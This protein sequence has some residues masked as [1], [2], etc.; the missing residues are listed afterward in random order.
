M[1]A[2]TILALVMAAAWACE[3]Q[4]NVYSFGIYSCGRSYEKQWIVGRGMTCFGYEQYEQFLDDRG[5]DVTYFSSNSR[6]F[7][8]VH[9][10]PAHVRVPG[11]ARKVAVVSGALSLFVL[12]VLGLYYFRRRKTNVQG[13]A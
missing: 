6:P 10:G 13:F 3:A 8:E 11:T 7:T 4:S 12:L 2:I 9:L 1:R 5:R